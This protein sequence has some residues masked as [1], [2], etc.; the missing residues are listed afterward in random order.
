MQP[1]AGRLQY[2]RTGEGVCIEIPARGHWTAVLGLIFLAA[3]VCLAIAY[4][5]AILPGDQASLFAWLNV[6]LGIAGFLL[7]GGLLLWSL[8]G[9]TLVRL[10]ASEIRL[11]RRVAGV[12]W[13][14]RAFPADSVGGLRYVP[15]DSLYKYAI[16]SDRHPSRMEIS[17]GERRYRFARGIDEREAGALMEQAKSIVGFGT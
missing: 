5:R 1:L 8:T 10:T 15:P 3:W 13:D 2:E 16:N 11:E 14:E 17:V 6:G 9:R 4:R 12:P 7:V